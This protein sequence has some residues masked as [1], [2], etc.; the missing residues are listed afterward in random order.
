MN[1]L[2]QNLNLA[3][4]FLFAKVMSDKVIC[5]KVL[6]EILNIKIQEIKMPEQ[7][8]VIDLVLDSKSVRLDIYVND[9]HNTIYNVEMQKSSH[10]NLAK[11]SRYYQGN[12]DLD[13]IQKGED[14]EKL[15]KSFVIFICTFD[16]F[17]KG[18]HIY[19]FQNQINLSASE[20]LD[21]FIYKYGTVNLQYSYTT[22]VGLFKSIVAVVLLGAGNFVAKK[23]T[24]SGIF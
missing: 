20:V 3:D 10:K 11:R 9:E 1:K 23:T 5:K 18:R 16:P 24:G 8:K 15:R 17:N 21:T 2:I 7:Q 13:M 22:A 4:D 6:E 14:Y 12:I 19:T